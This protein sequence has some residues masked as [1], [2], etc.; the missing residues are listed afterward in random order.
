[1]TPYERDCGKREWLYHRINYRVDL[2]F[3]QWL[4]EEI[5]ELI[6]QWYDKKSFGMK[7]IGYSEYFQYL[8]WEIS[9]DQCKDMIKQ[10][11]RNYAKRQLTWFRKY[12]KFIEFSQ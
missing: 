3:E 5:L 11:T 12:E 8:D 6:A 1:L 9:L 4:E 10:N 7:S 2:M